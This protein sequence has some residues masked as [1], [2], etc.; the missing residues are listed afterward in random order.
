MSALYLILF[1]V[2]G[3]FLGPTSCRFTDLN[4]VGWVSI[5]GIVALIL[6]LTL[7][8]IFDRKT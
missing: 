5:A 2:F 6:G 3:S 8:R 7:L 4:P 1:L